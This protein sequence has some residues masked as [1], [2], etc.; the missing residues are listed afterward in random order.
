MALMRLMGSKHISS[1][2]V[3][4]MTTLRTGLRYR[5]DFPLLCC[6]T[7]ECF[8]R[9]VETA[10]LGPL[11][12]HVIVALLPLIP[13]QPKETAAII[14]FLILDNREEVNDYLHEIYFLP[15]HPELKDIHT[16]LQNYK[17][18]HLTVL[19]G[20]I[21]HKYDSNTWQLLVSYLHCFLFWSLNA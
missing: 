5:E 15:D 13:L 11:L 4:M 7:W 16:V 3:K 19:V 9:S 1:V 6:Q 21:Q 10:H 20:I 18:V 17:K 12:S 8:V 14:R 2:R